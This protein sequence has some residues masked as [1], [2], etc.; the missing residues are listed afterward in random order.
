MLGKLL[1]L[2]AQTAIVLGHMQL[3]EPCPRYSFQCKTQPTLP[4]GETIDYNLSTPIG[5]NG[6]ILAP[7]CKH[8]EPWPTVT[9]T[10]TAGQPVTVEFATYGATHSGGHCEFSLSYDGGQTYVVVHQELRYCFYTGNPNSG[11]SGSVRS[12]TFDLPSSVPGTDHAVFAWSWVNASGN[13]EFYSNCADVAIAGA[14]GS[15]S[16]KLI[17]F[18]NYGADYPLIPEFL[19]NYDTGIEFYTTNVTTVTVSGPGF[20]AYPTSTA[21]STSAG[22]STSSAPYSATPTSTA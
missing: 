22:S 15:Y 2:L 10:W 8:T 17:T 20:S 6:N 7:F 5:S 3:T 13:R 11:G 19:G 18:A 21:T 16:A 4:A 9:S 12:Y 14:P 1:S